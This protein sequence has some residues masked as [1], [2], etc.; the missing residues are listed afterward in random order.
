MDIKML[1]L[2]L[3]MVCASTDDLV[4]AD[5]IHPITGVKKKKK[6]G[7]KMKFRL[8]DKQPEED[9]TSIKVSSLAPDSEYCFQVRAIGGDPSRPGYWSNIACFRTLAGKPPEP[10]GIPRAI[11]TSER[12]LEIVWDESKPRGY[13]VISYELEC[14]K[15]DLGVDYY[16]KI[17]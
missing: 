10:P 16:V 12:T 7:I 11:M 1:L 6:K 15:M 13:H 17:Q 14:H 9:A 2:L 5:T 4:T 8:L 3:Q